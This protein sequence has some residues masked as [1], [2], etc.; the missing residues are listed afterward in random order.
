V[1]V[2]RLRV[3]ALSIIG[4]YK[5]ATPLGCGS[6]RVPFYKYATPLGVR[7]PARPFLQICHPAGVERIFHTF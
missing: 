5:Y 6:P 1:R 3:C 7:I 2:M 4:C